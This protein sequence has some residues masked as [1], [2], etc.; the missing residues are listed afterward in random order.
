[1]DSELIKLGRRMNLRQQALATAQVYIRRF[2]TKVE[3]RKTNPYLIMATAVYLACKMEECP[4]HIRLMLGEAARQWPGKLS[5]SSTRHERGNSTRL[6][7]RT[8]IFAQSLA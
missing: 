6:R 3:I 1:M 8:L 2:Y 7:D 4:Q 5:S